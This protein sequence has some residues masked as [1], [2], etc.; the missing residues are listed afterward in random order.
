MYKVMIDTICSNPYIKEVPPKRE[1]HSVTYRNNDLWF[2]LTKMPMDV[3]RKNCKRDLPEL[4]GNHDNMN[5]WISN[6]WEALWNPCWILLKPN[7][8]YGIMH[9][10]H[11]MRLF[12]AMDADN[13]W[14]YV[15]NQK[16][17]IKELP[18]NVVVKLREN[19][20][21]PCMGSRVG[22]CPRCKADVR[23]RKKTFNK[24]FDVRMS[25]PACGADDLYP[26][27]ERL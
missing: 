22:K 3:I 11:R 20:R 18:R 26:Y 8:R 24:L 21:V 27:P 17:G 25:C 14:C 23:F 2:G 15:M 10:H 19:D 7:G 12:D 16:V 13:V 5:L 1:L 9:G 6:I 4:Q